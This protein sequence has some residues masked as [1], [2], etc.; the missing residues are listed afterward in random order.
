MVFANSNIAELLIG[1]NILP[2]PEVQ[3]EETQMI[4]NCIV[5]KFKE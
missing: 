1:S 2:K 3:A 4:P 5:V